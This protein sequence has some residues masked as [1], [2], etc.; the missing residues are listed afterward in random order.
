LAQ[1]NLAKLKLALGPISDGTYHESF[2]Y[3]GYGLS[4][5]LPFWTALARTGADYTDM[6]ILRGLGKHLLYNEIPDVPRQV[7][8]PAGDFS[9]WSNQQ[10]VEIARYTAAR[11]RDPLAAAAAKRWLDAGPRTTNVPD[12]WYEVFEFLY[13]DPTVVPADLHAQ[14]L[15][16]DFPDMGGAILHSSWDKGD[17]AALTGALAGVSAR[18]AAGAPV[19]AALF[20]AGR[21]ADQGGTRELLSSRSARSI[22]ADLQGTALAVTGDSIA[23]FHAY[24]PAATSV[25]LNG[26][27]VSATFES[28][29]ITYQAALPGGGTGSGGSAADGGT[30]GDTKSVALGGVGSGCSTGASAGWLAGLGALALFRRRRT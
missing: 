29:M 26:T 27:A 12:L 4:M 13:Y 18:N 21:I 10:Q 9:G 14:P 23:D 15:D 16:A 28:G 22:E 8:L 17:L 20:G 6:G 19:R 5:S 30:A 3:E 25:T 1:D 24:S 7:I 2:G 11:F